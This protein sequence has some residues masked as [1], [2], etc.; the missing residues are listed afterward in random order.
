MGSQKDGWGVFGARSWT[1]SLSG[2]NSIS[3]IESGFSEYDFLNGTEPYKFHWA[4]GGRSSLN[5]FY[6]QKKI[7]PLILAMVK[8][9]KYTAKIMMR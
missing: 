1:M 5:L 4:E 2:T 9:L 7:G 3:A 6:Y 8:F